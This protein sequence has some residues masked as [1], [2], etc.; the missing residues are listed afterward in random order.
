MNVREIFEGNDPKLK[1]DYAYTINRFAY[2]RMY[3]KNETPEDLA[4]KKITDIYFYA[5][6]KISVKQIDWLIKYATKFN[7]R[8]DAKKEMMARIISAVSSTQ[9]TDS[10]IN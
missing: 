2:G 1:H 5:P 10:S 6:D 9:L 3:T 8:G 4:I 7:I